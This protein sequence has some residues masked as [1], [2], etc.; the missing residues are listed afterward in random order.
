MRNPRAISPGVWLVATVLGVVG[1]GLAMG[2]LVWL[3]GLL[4]Q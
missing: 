3:G 4:T 2:F 1:V